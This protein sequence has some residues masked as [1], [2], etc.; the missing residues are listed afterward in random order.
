MCS[1]FRFFFLVLLLIGVL[2]GAESTSAQT[3]A[4]VPVWQYT[5]TDGAA[6]GLGL[7]DD[8]ETLVAVVGFGFDPG[9]QIVSL[10]PASGDVRWTVE[11]EEGALA[12][13]IV[14]DG[15]VYAGMGSL[16]G[17]GAAVYALDAATGAELWRTDVEN[18]DLPGTPIDAISYAD[19]TLY[20]NR[21][22]AVLLALDAATGA[23]RWEV[24]LQKPPRG[25]PFVDGNTVYVSTGFDGGRIFAFDAQTGEERWSIE[26]SAN[27][28][29]GPVL[30]KGILYVPF[31]DGQ[32]VAY[33]PATGEERWR[34]RAGLRD[35]ATEVDPRAGLPLIDNGVLFVSSN[36][37]AGAFTVAYDAATGEELWSVP[38]GE[39]SAGAP[40]I[41]GDVLLVGSDSGDVLALDPSTG[42]ELWRV[43]I[44]NGI[45]LDLNQ[46]SP[47]LIAGNQIFVR[48]ETGGV[49][50]LETI[51]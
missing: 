31:V 27:P 9:G 5:L 2:S 32:L 25:G 1:R 23:I 7:S 36:G 33:D 26:D 50:A 4:P 35:E 38:T 16:V 6:Y 40:A 47:P 30:A 42:A 37:F 24:E 49:V 39:F 45:D 41:A 10:D 19:G 8:G 13:P 43:A 51:G 17:G 34:V 29:T 28:V 48:D 44:P 3:A 12:D 21:G 22:D 14:S 18:R 46:A 20:V 11:T 15:M